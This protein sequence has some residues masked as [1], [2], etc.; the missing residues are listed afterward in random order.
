MKKWYIGTLIVA[1]SAL[2]FLCRQENTSPNQEMILQFQSL[3]NS[4]T[5]AI[6]INKVKAQLEDLGVVNIQVKT[7][8]AGALKITYFSKVSVSNIKEIFSEENTLPLEKIPFQNKQKTFKLEV[9]NLEEGNLAN[10]GL[11]GKLILESKQEYIRYSNPNV[12]VHAINANTSRVSNF[13]KITTAINSNNTIA[14]SSSLA[15]IPQV[16]AGPYS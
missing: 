15:K 9:F 16:R 8:P 7:T 12:F 13:I 1:I 10:S 5:K 14:I 4:E 3:L 2:T 11:N 6:T